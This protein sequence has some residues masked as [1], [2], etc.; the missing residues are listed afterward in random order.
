M[1][2]LT[3]LLI[4][5][6]LGLGAAG[7]AAAP[8]LTQN[9]GAIA[10][11]ATVHSKISVGTTEDETQ[12]KATPGIVLSITATNTNA[13]ARYLKCYDLTAANAAPGTSTPWLRLAVPPAAT[14]GALHVTFPSGAIFTTALTCALV[15]GSADSDVAEVAAGELMWLITYK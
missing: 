7:G 6:A 8:M 11:G 10:N 2:R 4:V 15:T 3:V 12:I 5:L 1:R 13:A 9:E 14:S